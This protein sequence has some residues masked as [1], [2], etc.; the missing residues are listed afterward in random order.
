MIGIVT[1]IEK[2]EEVLGSLK[3]RYESDLGALARA[4]KDALTDEKSPQVAEQLISLR[5]LTMLV[6][7]SAVIEEVGYSEITHPKELVAELN[8]HYLTT[9]ASVMSKSIH[10]LMR[11]EMS[12]Q[13]LDQLIKQLVASKLLPRR[14]TVADLEEE[15]LTV[16]LFLA[17]H[18]IRQRRRLRGRASSRRYRME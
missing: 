2:L 1:W 11:L 8:K 6:I 18:S 13:L 4:L 9:H 17:A 12:R 5:R 7:E 16:P 3:D 10:Q 14:V 15:Y